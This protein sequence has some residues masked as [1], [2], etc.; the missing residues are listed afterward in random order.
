MNTCMQ[1]LLSI[2][3]FNHYFINKTYN[4]EKTSSKKSTS[5]EALKDFIES[6]SS[7]SGSI[8]PTS[9]LYDICHSFLRPREQHDCQ[10]FLRRLLAK[11]QEELNG[12][13]KYSVPDQ[14]YFLKAWKIYKDN[15]PT[16]IDTIFSGL[17]RSSVICQ[18]CN[19]QSGKY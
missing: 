10:E 2:P 4:A 19:H 9:G 8:R 17:L 6:Y 1:C 13:K 15:N 11:I 12:L 5:C 14:C 18:K 7:S 3:E 16:M